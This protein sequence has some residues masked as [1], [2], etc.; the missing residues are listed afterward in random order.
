LN[1]VLGAVE[2]SQSIGWQIHFSRQM[3]AINLSWSL[4]AGVNFIAVTRI[5]PFN[6]WFIF[7]AAIVAPSLFWVL[8]K[9]QYRIG[10]CSACGYDLRATPERCPECG[11]TPKQIQYSN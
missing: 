6:E 5:R 8:R 9:K 7:S 2:M 11:A 1:L 3:K 10:L 4:P